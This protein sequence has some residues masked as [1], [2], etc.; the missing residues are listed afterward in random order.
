MSKNRR[1]CYLR[2]EQ[3]SKLIEDNRV[4]DA[5]TYQL[6]V[7]SKSTTSL[8]NLSHL[9]KLKAIINEVHH[10][11]SSQTSQWYN[12]LEAEVLVANILKA[13][14]LSNAFI[15][16]SFN[17]VELESVL[18]EPTVHWLKNQGFE[19]FVEVSMGTKIADV[20]GYKK[21]GIFTSEFV[22]S[23]ELKNDRSQ[24]NRALNQLAEF[25]D[26]SHQVY[27]GCT[28]YCAA[29]EVHHHARAPGVRTWDGQVLDRKLERHGYG[30]L[31]LEGKEV[32]IHLASKTLKPNKE[33]LSELKARLN[34][35][36]PV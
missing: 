35:M 13:E 36:T 7:P 1:Y 18:T 31:L 3:L 20:L 26:Y 12:V 6:N 33:K 24:M 5:L 23:I 27:L 22:I 16:H 2:H 4:L 28:P 32:F 30:F 29:E 11:S 14:K 19:V 10:Q 21:G 8:K 25:S 17:A 34:S 15:T 9:E